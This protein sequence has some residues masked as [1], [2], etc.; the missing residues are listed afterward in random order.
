MRIP[1]RLLL[2]SLLICLVVFTASAGQFGRLRGKITTDDG[3]PLSQANVVVEGTMK[4]AA[5]DL[6]GVY[7][8]LMLTPGVY[9]IKVSTIGYHEQR[10]ENV[11]IS[12][13]ETTRLNV[14]LKEQ[15]INLDEVV[16]VFKKP[17][18][19]LKETSRRVDVMGEV[20]REMPIRNTAEV[21][22]VQGGMSSDASGRLHLRGGRSGEIAYFIDGQRIEDPN[23][24]A[25]IA[26]VS[27]DIV[28]E[29]SVLS[30]TFNA[31][32][33]EAMSGI[34]N[35]VT[36]EGG[37]DYEVRV[38]YESPRL[39]P[40]PYREEDWV[41]DGSDA[42][43]DP[44]TNESL[45]SPGD[46]M[47]EDIDLKVPGRLSLNLSGPLPALNNSTFFVNFVNE[48]QDSYLP[49][50]YRWDRAVNG[51]LAHT[52]KH[53]KLVVSFGAK[54]TNRKG[55]SH[56]WKYN[57]EQYHSHFEREQRLSL[58]WTQNLTPDLYYTASAGLFDRSHDV[59]IFEEWDDYLA[60]GYQKKDFTFAQYFYNR[61]DWSDTWRESRNKN[62]NAK[63]K[64]TWRVNDV[65]L[66]EAGAT[67]QGIGIDMYDI[68]ELEIGPNG[69]RL[70][71]VDSYKEDPVEAAVFIQDQIELDYLIVNAGLRLDYVDPRSQ[72]WLNPEDPSETLEDA[73][74]SYQVSPRIGLA[75]P[76][77][78]RY[79]LHFA[80]GHFFQFPDYVNLFMNSAD[81]SPDTLAIR[82]FDAVGSRTLKPQKTV[83]YEV[84]LKG[85]LTPDWGMSLTAFYK[86]IT[87]LVGTRQVRLGTSYNYAA[88]INIDYASVI[89]FEV[90]LNKNISDYWSLQ[91]NYTLSV[92]KGNSSEPLEGFWNAYYE[93][94]EARQEYYMDF[95]RR[96]T[97][98]AL[99]TWQT[100]ES[101]YP[102]LMGT[103]LLKG[104]SA[105]FIFKFA[106]G[107]PYTPYSGIGEQLALRNSERM[108]YTLQMDLR[109]AKTLM[110]E[111]AKVILFM[112]ADN[113]FDRVN[114]LFVNSRT[115]DPWESTL[116]SN[117]IAFDQNHNPANV[118][119]PR[120]IR[121]GVSVEY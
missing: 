39:N 105:G 48:T 106:S 113:L 54:T 84:G 3:T 56:A 42:V 80:Y 68:R 73:D 16:L 91:A 94:P 17:P 81:L 92:A 100:G 24:G 38:E 44:L 27:R 82:S 118:D 108:E 121:V 22:A 83:S 69:E 19:S 23:E 45:Y 5:T 50:G 18:V 37:E 117:D 32:Y 120:I 34:V 67:H 35:I 11:I 72:G 102:K 26:D 65:H 53:G 49:F 43:R 97:A 96:H 74:A 63:A 20:V 76:I 41:K 52:L 46:V 79:T 13:N 62:W 1:S 7:Y 70:G 93:Q 9:T 25:E 77:S 36:R 21:V 14:K 10:I 95:D 51:K 8:I 60:S 115:G 30:G 57:P 2:A 12:H 15:T 64:L 40:S 75:H 119:M 116:V 31:E 55:Y 85:I 78:D 47:D 66:V 101:S 33:G 71:I 59:K 114:P 87:D 89:G 58:S 109:L 107:L 29:L 99:L 110:F 90:G 111:P 103:N 6:D 104:M 4:G 28:Q 112:N 61:D 88:F 86:D 98:N